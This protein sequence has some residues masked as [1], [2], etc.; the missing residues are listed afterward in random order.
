VTEQNRVLITCP[1]MLRAI[2]RYRPTFAEHQVDIHCPDVV[3][4]LTE[5][6]LVVLLPEFDGWIIGDDPA[7][8]A[9][10]SAGRAGRLR[11]AVKWGIGVDNVDREAM[12]E[13]GINFANTPEVFGSEV[14]DIALGYLIGI[15][16]QT[17]W[18][19]RRIREG[20]WPKPRGASLAGKTVALIGFGD[21]G[22][23]AARRLL[24]LEMRVVA[25]DPVFRR[26]PGLEAVQRGT[27]PE[28]IGEA[29]FLVL[30]CALTSDNRHMISDEVLHHVKKGVG[31]VNVARGPLIDES[32]LVRALKDGRVGSAA[33]D[34]FEVEPLPM[35]SPLRDHQQC[36][37]GSHNASNTEDGVARTSRQALHHMLE[38][39]GV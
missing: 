29:D 10:L 19:D 16:R 3:Q 24:S 11:C 23:H 27:W 28:A 15:S 14:A 18:I 33:L 6:E 4:T 2:D 20:D 9:V 26:V 31:V 35:D 13:L 1:P 25:Y 12:A 37:L 30:T 36:I 7:T 32:A 39:L 22:Q 34:V 38:F 21:I 17:F 5:E 8:R